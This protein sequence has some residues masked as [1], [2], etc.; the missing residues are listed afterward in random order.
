M[1]PAQRC[2][3]TDLGVLLDRRGARGVSA[4]IACDRRDPINAKIWWLADP[5]Y[6]EPANERRVEHYARQVMISIRSVITP[7]E[8]YDWRDARGGRAIREML[9]RYGWPAFSAWAGRD[10]DHSH[11]LYLGTADSTTLNGGLFT[12]NEYTMPRA[13][14]VPAWTAILDPFSRVFDRLDGVDGP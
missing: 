8:R 2:T 1:P 14:T 5:L 7:S 13:H 12:T 9:I 6:S 10:E 4:K 11:Y 3:W